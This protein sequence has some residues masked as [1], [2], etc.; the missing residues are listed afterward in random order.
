[1]LNVLELD[2]ECPRI[3]LNSNGWLEG[4]VW[5]STR[6]N[7]DIFTCSHLMWLLFPQKRRFEIPYHDDT[8]ENCFTS[9]VSMVVFQICDAQP[10]KLCVAQQSEM[11]FITTN[12]T[13]SI[14]CTMF[15]YHQ[16][17]TLSSHF[18]VTVSINFL[19]HNRHTENCITGTHSV[20]NI[21]PCKRIL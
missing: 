17:V 19:A 4:G 13:H 5:K 9:I 18:M 8:K 12:S 15:S 7:S 21:Q 2:T 3:E 11:L 10:Q 14:L 16:P 20:S 6:G 1:M